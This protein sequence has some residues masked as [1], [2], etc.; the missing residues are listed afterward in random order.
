MEKEAE[1]N[2]ERQKHLR[3]PVGFLTQNGRVF[4]MRDQIPQKYVPNEW[5]PLIGRI[6]RGEEQADDIDT[7]AEECGFRIGNKEEIGRVA[8]DK[9]QEFSAGRPVVFDLYRCEVVAGE[10]T[11]KELLPG[12]E[13]SPYNAFTQFEGRWFDIKDLKSE[14]NL[15]ILVKQALEGFGLK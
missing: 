7:Q 14:P 13:N 15:H 8:G 3:I 2:Q 1:E 11:P 5:R 12:L 10:F 4:L 9:T 6:W